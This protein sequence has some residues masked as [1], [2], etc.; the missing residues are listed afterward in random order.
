MTSRAKIILL[1]CGLALVGAIVGA[2]YLLE[3]GPWKPAKDPG[4]V[5]ARVD[6]TPIYLGDARSRLAGLT[7]VHGDEELG[8]EWEG[9]LLQSLVDDVLMR[10]EAARRGIVLSDAEVEAGLSEVRQGFGTE[11]S[12]QE[13]LDSN[14]IDMAELERRARL[15]MLSARVYLD[16]TSSVKVDGAEIRAYYRKHTED[17]EREDGTTAPLLEVRSSIVEVLEK[18]QKDRIFG[19]WLD[20]QRETADLTVLI[21]DWWRKI[22]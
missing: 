18:K 2:A 11:E 22:Q 1:A 16:M 10:E 15:N 21:D 4:P 13:W 20:E 9:R 5:M 14:N 8:P 19:D 3:I 12:F 7:S 6:G 17:Y